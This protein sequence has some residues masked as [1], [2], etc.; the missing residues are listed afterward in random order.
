MCV[1]YIALTYFGKTFVFKLKNKESFVVVEICTLEYSIRRNTLDHLNGFIKWDF[2][3]CRKYVL[4]DFWCDPKKC[5]PR[6]SA[7]WDSVV[8][9]S[10]LLWIHLGFGLSVLVPTGCLPDL[11]SRGGVD[12]VDGAW[13]IF[14]P[15]VD[16]ALHLLDIIQAFVN[17]AFHLD[18]LGE[19]E[20]R[21]DGMPLLVVPVHESLNYFDQQDY[22]VHI[23][24]LFNNLE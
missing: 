18:Q 17:T 22:V 16:F 13:Q 2:E 1:N 8:I 14:K 6:R 11:R 21:F 20:I 7:H 23:S 10:C 9:H 12:N 19:Q 15:H 24:P 4:N 3:S 5:P